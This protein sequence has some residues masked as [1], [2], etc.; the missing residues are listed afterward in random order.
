MG[1][2]IYIDIEAD[3]TRL[4]SVAH[5]SAPIATVLCAAI[6]VARAVS[7]GEDARRN[8]FRSNEVRLGTGTI[9]SLGPLEVWLCS[10]SGT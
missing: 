9:L 2:Y 8:L 4:W 3:H 7:S 1:I 6:V 10:G 5:A